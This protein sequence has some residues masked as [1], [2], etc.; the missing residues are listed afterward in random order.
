MGLPECE[1][2]V[3]HLHTPTRP[4]LRH[5]GFFMRGRGFILLICSW[6]NAKVSQVLGVFGD[7]LCSLC[8]PGGD[9]CSAKGLEVRDPMHRIVYK[10]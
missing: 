1:G 5:L 10:V 6:E 2:E 8:S 9:A 3:G 7:V 4:L